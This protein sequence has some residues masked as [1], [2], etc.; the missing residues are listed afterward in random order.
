M[1]GSGW[2]HFKVLLPMYGDNEQKHIYCQPG[3]KV[4]YQHSILGAP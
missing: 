4:S 3:Q 1:N 2:S